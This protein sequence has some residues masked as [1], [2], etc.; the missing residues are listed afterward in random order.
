MSDNSIARR[1]YRATYAVL[2]V[3]VSAYALLQSFVLPVLPTIEHDLH[4]SESAVTWVLTAYL[5]SA[6][7]FTPILGRLGDLWGKKRAFM[8]ALFALGIGSLLAALAHSID[9]MIVARVIQ[10]AGGGMLPLAFGIIRDDFPERKVVG[11]VSTT[12]AVAAAGGAVGI[13][14]AGP[15]L[16]VLD[17]HWLFWL[18]MIAVSVAMAAAWMFIPESGKRSATR[19]NVPA[20][21]L[22]SSWLIALLLAVSEGSDWGWSSPRVIGLL[23]GALAIAL[24]W[25]RVELDSSHPLIDMRTMRLPAVWT[26]NL[27]AFLFGFGLY[28]SFTFIPQYVQA[29]PSIGYG[30]GAT[31]TQ[32]GFFLL[33]LSTLMFVGG[34]LTGPASARFG[35]KAVVCVGAILSVAGFGILTLDLHAQLAIYLGMGVL[36]VGFGLALSGTSY[37]IVQSVDSS[38]TAVASGMNANIRT[39]GGSIGAAAMSSVVTANAKAHSLP[40]F[41]GYHHGFVMLTV[42]ALFGVAST[43]LVPTSRRRTAPAPAAAQLEVALGTE[44]VN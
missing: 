19:L 2:M 10:G 13:V 15:L 26:T 41:S 9:L 7:V 39:I 4:T 38:Q 28:A 36:G 33:P 37:L 1:S 42:G 11:A 23:L 17:F 40:L 29:P 25:I 31:V 34:F 21:L 43:L 35:P 3:G 27:V 44:E 20:A 6:A 12:A 32:S 8:A 14:L 30:F 18:P 16:K 22:L 5:L 24:L